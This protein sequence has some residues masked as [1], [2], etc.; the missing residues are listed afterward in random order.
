MAAKTSQFDTELDLT[1]D[2][3]LDQLDREFWVT[4]VKQTCFGDENLDG[5]F[6]RVD[7]AEVL[8]AD[9]YMD[10]VVGNST[11]ATGDWNG[12]GEFDALDL[13]TALQGSGYD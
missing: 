1:N 7:L 13:V 8:P 3:I 11:W 6:D 5:Q 9:E 2:G 10:E 12:D 4:W